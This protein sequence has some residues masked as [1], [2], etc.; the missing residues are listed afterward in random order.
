MNNNYVGLE[1]IVG[2]GQIKY[3]ESMKE[4]TTMKVGGPCDAII[5]PSCV[6]EI[7]QIV[8]YCKENSIKY[9]V[10]G[11]GSNL[12]VRDEGIHA[13]IIRIG[14]KFSQITL[15]GEYLKACSGATMPLLSQYAKK[16][17][18]AG[19]EFAC[20]IPGTIGGGV[21]MNAGAYGWQFSD[22]LEEVSY[23]DE[24]LNIKTIKS[25][26]CKFG[27]RKSIFQ[28][29]ENYIILSA[30]FKLKFSNV[31]EIAKKMEENSIARK[32]K[33]PLE[34]PNFGSVFK[35]PEGYFVGKLISDAGLRGYSIGG[36]QVSTKHTGFIVNY[37]N[38]TC[39]D[40]TDLIK[41]IQDVVLEKFNV[42][43]ETEVIIIGGKK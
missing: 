28:E 12:L 40:V 10:V 33:Q 42:K 21:R 1:N 41:Y 7:I 26:E 34:Y 23:L 36:A 25:S 32:T 27:Y 15:E 4:H 3:N 35:R 29:N 43:L 13:L 14:H 22:V 18:L 30:T 20:G 17:S 8:N 16:N 31:E 5:F 2:K 39:K 9:Y 6:E 11:N 19:L 37:K 38:A 24:K